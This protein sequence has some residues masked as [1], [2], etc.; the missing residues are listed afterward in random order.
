MTAE[1]GELH[2]RAEKTD[3][4]NG[5]RFLDPVAIEPGLG[6]GEFGGR[7]ADGSE[8]QQENAGGLLRWPRKKNHEEQRGGGAYDDQGEEEQDQPQE[9]VGGAELRDG[10]LFHTLVLRLGEEAFAGPVLQEFAGA[11]SLF[12]GCAVELSRCPPE[13]ARDLDQHHEHGDAG[14]D[15]IAQDSGVVIDCRG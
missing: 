3:R 8:D 13:A 5:E 10:F 11:Q 14:N 15:E 12:A 4:A 9:N 2:S 7:I 6:N 1:K